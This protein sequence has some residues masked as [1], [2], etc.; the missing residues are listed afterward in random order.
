MCTRSVLALCAALLTC[1]VHSRLQPPAVGA[2]VGTNTYEPEQIRLSY[3]ND[4]TAM[5]VTWMT[6]DAVASR[7]LF[8]VG[9][10][11]STAF[12]ISTP[13]ETGSRSETVHRATLTGLTPGAQ[14]EYVVGSEHG[15]SDLKT[16]IAVPAGADWSPRLAVFGDMGVENARSLERL[17]LDAALGMYDAVLHIG[18]FAY[19]LHDDDGKV[20]DEFLRMVEPMTARVPY[21]V[22]AGNHEKH[23]NFSEYKARFTM[24]G[25]AENMFYKFEMGPVQFV[26]IS[27]EFYYYLEYGTHM[28]INQYSW[29]DA[30]L[31]EANR[32]ESRALRPWLVVFGHR[33]MYCS[34]FDDGN[35]CLSS[36]DLL[37]VGI[38]EQGIPGVEPLL[39]EY[40]VDLALWGHVHA[41]E[42]LWPVYGSVVMNGT[43]EEPYT[44][45]GAPVHLIS[46]SAGAAK[47]GSYPTETPRE[48]SAYR[49]IE[50]GFTRL[51]FHN[52]SHLNIEQ[53]SEDQGGAIIDSTWLKKTAHV[54]YHQLTRTE[55]GFLKL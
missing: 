55:R 1:G 51:T 36:A 35:D 2:Q 38:P 26:C 47:H 44:N 23:L 53:V 18:D 19:D 52:S 45:P 28:A 21:M 48:Y 4:P 34:N 22:T 13:F 14:Y 31:K 40:G 5:T 25:E 49:S 41:Y 54:P 33:P 8:G 16:F 29:L 10:L 27:S 6:K 11:N 17:Q 20:G 15:W 30:V 43:A 24:P 32:P 46:G 37:R 9:N 7:A 42:R 12:G 39:M 3:L 50:Y